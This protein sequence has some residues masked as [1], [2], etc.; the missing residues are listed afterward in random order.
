MIVT[1]APPGRICGAVKVPFASIVPQAPG[2]AA[3]LRLHRIVGSGCPEL[4]RVA[5]KSCWAP[6]STVAAGEETPS[7]MS[8][9]I[10]TIAVAMIT[11]LAALAAVICTFAGDGK[12][13]GAVN[14]PS[15]EIVPAALLPPAIPFTLQFTAALL[16]PVTA[17]V[18]C[19]VFPSN[20]LP[21]FDVIDTLI[22]AGGGCGL[23]PGLAPPP[24]QPERLAQATASGNSQ[25]LAS[26]RH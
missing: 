13:D 8:L 21:L 4:V 9:V 10:V 3:P 1:F 12:S 23:V 6:N 2:H 24:P 7:T 17:A 26:D 14:I 19:K 18:S 16:V 20:T 11:G 5:A 22:V 15:A 25:P